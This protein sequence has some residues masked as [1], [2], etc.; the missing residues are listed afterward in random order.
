M[1]PE[2]VGDLAPVPAGRR[3]LQTG[4][5]KRAGPGG[6]GLWNEGVTDEQ[7]RQLIRAYLASTTY[8]DTQIGK[9]LDDQLADIKAAL[10]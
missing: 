6:N 9:L 7:A 1:Y 4:D 3:T 8:V 2:D 5:S 10:G